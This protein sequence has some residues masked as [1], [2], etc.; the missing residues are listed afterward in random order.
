MP[1]VR[2]VCGKL[3]EMRLGTGR[4]LYTTAKGRRLVVVLHAFVKKTGKIP[5]RAIDL[6]RQRA[7]EIK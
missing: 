6:A 2:H 5:R 3:W 7:K 1:H 4:A